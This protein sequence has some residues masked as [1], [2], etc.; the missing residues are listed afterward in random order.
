[1]NEIAALQ[2]ALNDEMTL[3][4]EARTALD[5]LVVTDAEHDTN[6]ENLRREWLRRDANV[7]AMAYNLSRI[8]V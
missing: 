6:H 5:A 2:A 3:Q 7:T 4:M 1:M 8:S